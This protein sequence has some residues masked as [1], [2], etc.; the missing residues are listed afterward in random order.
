MLRCCSSSVFPHGR[1]SPRSRDALGGH[2]RKA[3]RYPKMGSHISSP[4]PL[5]TFQKTQNSS[6][7]AD[8]ISPDT[9]A[10]ARDA[11][12]RYCLKETLN[13]SPRMSCRQIFRLA[14]LKILEI[15]KVFPQIFA[16][17]DKKFDCQSMHVDLSSASF[18]LSTNAQSN[19]ETSSLFPEIHHI[20]SGRGRR[21]SPYDMQI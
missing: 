8:R 18:R 21:I 16:L 13:K 5:P 2:V 17:P 1:N 14:V 10:K 3:F 15:H 20:R 7:R 11:F 12:Q 19:M 6:G 4:F 9:A